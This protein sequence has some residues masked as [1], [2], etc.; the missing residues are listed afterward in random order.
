MY[1]YIY[2]CVCVCVCVSLPLLLLFVGEI[3][4]SLD[5]PRLPLA[6]VERCGKREAALRRQQ[7][8]L[9][10]VGEREGLLGLSQNSLI[11]LASQPCRLQ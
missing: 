7:H 1:I 3:K 8:A 9:L 5:F 2:I 10:L 6:G 4:D 11:R